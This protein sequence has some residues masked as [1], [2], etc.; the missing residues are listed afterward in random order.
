MNEPQELLIRGRAGRLSV[1][2]KGLASR[3]QRGYLRKLRQRILSAAIHVL[4][5]I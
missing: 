5:A 3:P 1:H 2:I 4:H